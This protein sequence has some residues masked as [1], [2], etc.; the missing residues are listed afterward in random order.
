MAGSK[1]AFMEQALLQHALGNVVYTAP[2][3]WYVALSTLAF[4]PTATGAS[5]SEVTFYVHVLASYGIT[6]LLLTNAA[7]GV[8]PCFR[9]GDFMIVTDHINLMGDNPLRGRAPINLPRFVDLSCAYDLQL[10]ALL[11]QAASNSSLPLHSGIYLAVSGPN[12]ETPA[13]I[14]AFATLGADAVGMSTVPETLVAR[15][16]GMRVAALSCITNQAAGLCETP[17]SHAEVLETGERVKH[18]GVKLLTAFAQ[19]YAKENQT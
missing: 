3:T 2:G 12:Y 11:Q 8:N 17:L 1:T 5:M 4:D 13:E 18:L 7:G 9:A 19:L 10:R 16:S 15:R 14:R 6:A